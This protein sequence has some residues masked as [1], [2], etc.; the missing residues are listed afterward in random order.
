MGV[1][2]TILRGSPND[3]CAFRVFSSGRNQY[4]RAC[5]RVNSMSNGCW[6]HLFF[7]L[8]FFNLISRN[9]LVPTLLKFRQA[10][11][12]A[13]NNA[14]M[15]SFAGQK[16]QD[17]LLYHLGMRLS[18]IHTGEHKSTVLRDKPCRH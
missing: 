7:S 3:E 11:V 17:L 12:F 2:M 4:V 6:L 10:T 9:E 16:D 13:P 14:A 18:L 5:A 8:Q 1:G 15:R